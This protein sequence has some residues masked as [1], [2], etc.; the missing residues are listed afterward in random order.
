MATLRPLPGTERRAGCLRRQIRG[1]STWVRKKGRGVGEQAEFYER[2]TGR[3]IEQME[4]ASVAGWQKPWITTGQNTL[5]PVNAA[6]KREY[7][8]VN[9]LM[10]RAAAEITSYKDGRWASLEQPTRRYGSSR[11]KL[12]SVISR[13]PWMIRWIRTRSRLAE[14][15]MT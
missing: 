14:K 10:L 4:T 12:L 13:E 15:K 1:A 9:M 3:I 8:G 11:S 5:Q 7:R 6:T 2:I